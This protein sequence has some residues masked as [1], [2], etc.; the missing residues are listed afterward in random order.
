MLAFCCLIL[1]IY[2]SMVSTQVGGGVRVVRDW[3]DCRPLLVNS[4]FVS[5]TATAWQQSSPEIA[6]LVSSGGFI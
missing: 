2:L 5:K 4:V 6:N 1:S 3:M